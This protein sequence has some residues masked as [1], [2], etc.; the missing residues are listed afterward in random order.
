MD[1]KLIFGSPGTGKTDYLLRVLEDLLKTYEPEEIAFVSFTREGANQGKQR[2]IDKFNFQEENFPFFRTLH[3]I[4]F[5]QAKIKGMDL[6]RKN[7]Y[8]I[9]SEKMG[10]SF[11][12]YY[13]EEFKNN[14]DRYLFFNDVYR[15][16]QTCGKKYLNDLDPLKIKYVSENY[17]KFKKVFNLFDFTDLIE[18]FNEKNKALPVK[19][20]IVD[21][22][23]DLTSLQWRMVWTAFKNCD[24][25]Y[26]AG[27][28]DQSIYQWS[29]AD[30]NYFL[31]IAGDIT[32]LNKSHRLPSEVLTVAN[33]IVKR[34]K[35][36]VEKNT[37]PTGKKGAVERINNLNS[38]EIKNN[39]SYMFLTRNVCF[40]KDIENFLQDKGLLYFVKGEASFK[41]KDFCKIAQYKECQEKGDKTNKELDKI[42]PYLIKNYNLKDSWLTNFNWSTEK[43]NY[44]NN[45][46]KHKNTTFED[47]L[48]RANTIH[49]SKGS[50][51][52][53]VVLLTDITR[54]VYN[55]MSNE[56]SAED[57]V[58][59]VGATRAKK[60]LYIVNQ[61]GKYGYKI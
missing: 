45:V 2:A 31:D 53:N 12:G 35:N 49:S 57:R 38:V 24:T 34:I 60:K 27:D 9:F 4:A 50:E 16:N 58:F 3:S 21:E 48:F 18:L 41:I 14:D 36:R 19:I 17:K 28:D 44:Y 8:R 32:I 6:I 20:A 56:T 33:T 22:A 11:T 40:L 13:T 43:K 46:L 15:N 37:I 30:V 25:V 39:E 1:V 5:R 7:H 23:Q 29:G 26:I 54:N 42:K 52:D 55:S 51:A 61:R 59:Y 10:M 47:V